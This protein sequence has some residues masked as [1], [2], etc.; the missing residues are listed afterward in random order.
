MNAAA[1]QNFQ[2]GFESFRAGRLSEAERYFERAL[3]AD[4]RHVGAL[5]LMAMLK[6]QS[7]HPV[8]AERYYR[9]ALDLNASEATIYNYGL[10][11]KQLKR[12]AEA[13]DQLSRAISI[14]PSIPDT[15]NGRGAVLND[16]ERYDDAIADFDRALALKPDFAE[17]ASNKGRSLH[18]IRRYDDALAAYDG[19]LS[20]NAGLVEAWIGR[21]NVFAEINRHADA[22]AAYDRALALN[23]NLIEAWIGRGNVLVETNRILDGLVA[24]DKALMLKPSSAGAWLARGHA[25]IAMKRIDDALGNFDKAI[26][27]Q[28]DSTEA[29]FARGCAN[30]LA[31]R[32]AE[33]WIDYENRWD[34]RGCSSVRPD[35][36]IEHWSGEDL[37][38]RT[39]LVYDEQGFGDTIQFSRY[40]PRLVERGAEVTFLCSK[41]LFWLLESMSD[42]IRFATSVP[43][44]RFDFQCALMSLPRWFQTTLETI[45]PNRIHPV[46]DLTRIERWA[47][48]IGQ[49]GFRIGICWQGKPDTKMDVGRSIPLRCF[50]P[51]ARISNVRLISLQKNVGLD[52]MSRLP[53]EIAVETLGEEFD[54]GADA[55]ADTAAVM[56]S[57]DLIISSDTSIAHLAGSLDR[58]T[59]VALKYLPE[60]RWL[61]DRRTSPWYPSMRLFRQRLAG[62]WDAVFE[63]MSSELGEFIPRPTEINDS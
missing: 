57:L 7:P 10:L 44:T 4:S 22:L 52:Q 63:E 23:P 19:A 25:L 46:S 58:P 36:A 53:P 15:W 20:I 59:W 40:L 12:P 34:I 54:S 1:D 39:I 18:K 11:L 33:G 35:L 21:G 50:R 47:G 2:Q 32:M 41:K 14:N 17:A 45:P 3:H 6:A 27:I 37:T 60:W 5:N 9:A 56:A 51:L 55:F 28:A 49:T 31:G 38:G 24:F 26:S 13:L 30:L 42:K 61:L 8:E 43:D 29:L 48:K 16:L 62:D